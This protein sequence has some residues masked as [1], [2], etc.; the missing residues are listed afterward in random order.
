MLCTYTGAKQSRENSPGRSGNK[1]KR[2]RSKGRLRI[3]KHTVLPAPIWLKYDRKKRPIRQYGALFS[4]DFITKIHWQNCFTPEKSKFCAGSRRDGE[5][6]LTHGKPT[7]RRYPYKICLL[8]RMF[9]HVE[10]AI[11]MGTFFTG[12]RFDLCHRRS[13]DADDVQVCDRGRRAG[14]GN[15]FLWSGPWRGAAGFT[16]HLRD[17]Q[18]G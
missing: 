10:S 3:R 9:P 14:W 7:Q 16:G 18:K 15:G 4:A 5:G 12:D 8:R 17:T 6:M 13:G 2:R 1:C 11:G